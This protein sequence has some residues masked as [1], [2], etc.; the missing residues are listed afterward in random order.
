MKYINHPGF[1]IIRG[2]SQNKTHADHSAG[3]E[4]HNHSSSP[5]LH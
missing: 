5:I 1:S 3:A 4:F 2:T